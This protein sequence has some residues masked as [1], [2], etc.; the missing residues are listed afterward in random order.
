MEYSIVP[1]APTIDCTRS[2]GKDEPLRRPRDY[3]FYR[4]LGATDGLWQAETR[5]ERTG[6]MTGLKQAKVSGMVLF[7]MWKKT[8]VK[9]MAA[10]STSYKSKTGT[11]GMARG[12]KAPRR[13]GG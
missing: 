13:N 2:W 3:S 4:R 11:N 5:V 6:R 10:W 12:T 7:F 8:M 1:E 9:T